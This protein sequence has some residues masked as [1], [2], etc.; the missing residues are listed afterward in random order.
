MADSSHCCAKN[1]WLTLGLLRR[2]LRNNIPRFPFLLV[3]VKRRF[4]Q[5]QAYRT[6]LCLIRHFEFKK[7]ICQILPDLRPPWIPENEGSSP[8]IS[9]IFFEDV[10]G[11]AGFSPPPIFPCEARNFENSFLAAPTIPRHFSLTS[12]TLRKQTPKEFTFAVISSHT[13]VLFLFVSVEV[14]L[15]LIISMFCSASS[16]MTEHSAAVKFGFRFHLF[17][18]IV[19]ILARE[20]R[21]LAHADNHYSNSTTSSLSS[22]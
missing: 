8:K 19:F 10:F 4:L 13:F 3:P 1:K 18:A 20:A 14:N 15:L 9:I 16:K 2:I 7:K 12:L 17:S 6:A 21:A 22:G 11:E 5:V